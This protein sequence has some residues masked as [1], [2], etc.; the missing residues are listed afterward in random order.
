MNCSQMSYIAKIIWQIVQ[1]NGYIEGSCYL[2]MDIKEKGKL[3][4]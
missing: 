1:N 3:V 4:K 2:F